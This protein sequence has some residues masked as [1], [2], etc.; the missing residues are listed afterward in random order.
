MSLRHSFVNRMVCAGLPLTTVM[1]LVG[2][3][4]AGMTL[5][6]ALHENVN[7]SLKAL[8][9]LNA[10]IGE[11]STNVVMKKEVVEKMDTMR[12]EDDYSTFIMKLMEE[13]ARLK[14]LEE[15]KR[16][17]AIEHIGNIIDKKPLRI[18]V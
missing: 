17:K 3:R 9:V 14:A 13:N 11:D 6:Y 15:E 12:G 10:P 18:A 5:H 4:K 16:T 1:G 2:H 8:E 7:E